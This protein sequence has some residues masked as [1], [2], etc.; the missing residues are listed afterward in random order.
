MSFRL[1]GM[2]A[3]STIV[4]TAAALALAGCAHTA[5]VPAASVPPAHVS[6]MHT[7][8]DT[9]NGKTITLHIGDRLTVGLGSTYWEFTASTSSSV[10]AMVGTPV[11]AAPP[12]GTAHCY[13]GMGCGTVTATFQ[14]VKPGTSVVTASRAAC[15]EALRCTGNTGS[16]QLTVVV[17]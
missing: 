7:A 15:G 5:S 12:H 2:R 14:A 3:A 8:G 16:Y 6:A 9:D 10:L 11:T 4:I 13:P 1:P 17:G